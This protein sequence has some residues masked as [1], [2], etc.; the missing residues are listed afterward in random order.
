MNVVFSFKFS[1]TKLRKL[2]KDHRF[3]FEEDT[4][5]RQTNRAFKKGYPHLQL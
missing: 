1:Y 2:P 5:C 4:S 3:T